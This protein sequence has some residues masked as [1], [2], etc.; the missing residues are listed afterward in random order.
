MRRSICLPLSFAFTLSLGSTAIAHQAPATSSSI[1]THA[2][3]RTPSNPQIDELLER[4][5]AAY[6][7]RNMDELLAVWPSLRDSKDFKK[8]KDQFD[9]A[10]ILSM[11][12]NLK[13]ENQQPIG[14]DSAVVQCVRTQDY[15][16]L[17][18]TSQYSGDLQMNRMSQ[19]RTPDR[20]MTDPK[21]QFTRQATFG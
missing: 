21:R 11:Q 6:D 16:Q 17:E 18:T 2:E 1:D 12:L 3:A 8:I 15:V 20:P 10:D 14:S 4:Y 13:V 5:E 9:R 19:H 7:H